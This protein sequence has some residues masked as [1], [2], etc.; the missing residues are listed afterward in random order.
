MGKNSEAGTE[1]K[2]LRQDNS[3]GNTSGGSKASSSDSITKRARGRPRK[4]KKSENAGDLRKFL[5][6]IEG[7]RTNMLRTPEKRS[8][9]TYGW[10]I[11]LREKDEVNVTFTKSDFTKDVVDCEPLHITRKNSKKLSTKMN[12]DNN[13]HHENKNDSLKETEGNDG[14]EME[15]DEAIIDAEQVLRNV[16]D[17]EEGEIHDAEAEE[18]IHQAAVE[19]SEESHSEGH[20]NKQ[21]A[22]NMGGNKNKVCDNMG[23]GWEEKWVKGQIQ[24]SREMQLHI[25][26]K[27]EDA[28]NQ[29][30]AEWREEIC[31]TLEIREKNIGRVEAGIADTSSSR[32]ARERGSKSS[33]KDDNRFCED[34]STIKK[35][36][37][38]EKRAHEEEK[39]KWEL[40]CAQQRF[41]IFELERKLEEAQKRINTGMK[42]MGIEEFNMMDT[43]QRSSMSR[44]RGNYD[45]PQPQLSKPERD[46]EIGRGAEKQNVREIGTG[47]PMSSI[48]TGR[49]RGRGIRKGGIFEC[50]AQQVHIDENGGLIKN[51]MNPVINRK[52]NGTS[53]REGA[54]SS[55]GIKRTQEGE[56]IGNPSQPKRLDDAELLKELKERD[57]RRRNICISM[58]RDCGHIKMNEALKKIEELTGVKWEE[59]IEKSWEMPNNILRIRMK[60]MSE[61]VKLMKIKGNMRGSNIWIDDDLTT[62]EIEIQKWLK[63]EAEAEEKRGKREASKEVALIQGAERSGDSIS[64]DGADNGDFISVVLWNVAGINSVRETWP[65]LDR[66]KI[67]VLQGTWV[68]KEREEIVCKSLSKKFIWKMISAKRELNDR[69]KPKKGRAKGGQ[70]VGVRKD[71][72][73]EWAMEEWKYGMIIR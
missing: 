56:R 6:N 39:Q 2:A 12:D 14:V 61:K 36:M 24:L 23:C 27:I 28:K 35:A 31:K 25:K 60:E 43:M 3:E 57:W 19:E 21:D 52:D 11:P 49:G 10:T 7:A 73:K 18:V 65:F 51:G 47:I 63:K 30:R 46:R 64:E 67:V 48:G 38:L 71:V 33:T 53:V 1:E 68:E 59:C 41:K 54:Q 22:E 44:G 32:N 50:C 15:K 29:L 70:I 55:G 62:R 17:Y 45:T 16:S 42:E 20:Q 72:C 26:E 8:S 34:C 5:T 58:S 9:G 13:H 69:M 66:F 40:M 37:R 4:E